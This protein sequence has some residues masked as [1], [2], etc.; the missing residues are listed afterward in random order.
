MTQV[1]TDDG[2]VFPATVVSADPNVV[3]QVRT[4]DKDGYVA[5]QVGFG[6]KNKKNIKKLICGV[7]LLV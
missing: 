4:K 5:A 6:A 2:K 3:T 1:F 7:E